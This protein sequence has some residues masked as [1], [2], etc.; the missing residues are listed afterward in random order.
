[1]C[2]KKHRKDSAASVYNAR[3]SATVGEVVITSSLRIYG[4]GS[5]HQQWCK[6]PAIFVLHVPSVGR[7]GRPDAQ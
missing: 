7:N 2:R 6:S 5:P 3:F 1:M 4:A